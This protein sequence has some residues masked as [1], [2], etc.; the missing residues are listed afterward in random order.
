MT[1]ENVQR[2]IICADLKG[3]GV[4]SSQFASK[5]KE[6][7]LLVLTKNESTVKMFTA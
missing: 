7:G 1:Y 2:N 3:L 5:L 4:S 6:K